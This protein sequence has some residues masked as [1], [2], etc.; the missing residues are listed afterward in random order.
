M[1]EP[2]QKF[3]WN[4]LS[5]LQ[6]NCIG[7]FST[8]K[9]FIQRKFLVSSNET[10]KVGPVWLAILNL[11]IFKSKVK[12]NDFHVVTEAVPSLGPGPVGLGLGSPTQGGP[13][14]PV[15]SMVECFYK[16]IV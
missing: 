2:H 16:S 12:T 1:F 10:S 13:L 11:L 8:D 9:G 7:T 14:L 5:E 15:F 3:S 4:P 6:K